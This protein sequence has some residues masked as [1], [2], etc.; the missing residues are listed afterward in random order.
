MIAPSRLRMEQLRAHQQEIDEAGQGLAREYADINRE[1][2]RRKDGGARAPQPAPYIKGSS[3]TMGPFLTLLEP[4]RTSPQRPPCCMVSRRPRRPRIDALIGR[5]ARCS[6]AQPRSRRKVRCLDDANP[7]PASAHLQCIPPRTHPYTK[8]RRP[9]GS[10]PSSL[11]INASA[12]AATYVASSTL[13]DVP[14]ATREKQRA[15]A[16]IPDVA[17]ATTATRTEARAPSCQALRPLAGTSS[18]LRSL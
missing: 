13:G 15:A 5:F 17:G 12:V 7:T 3:P 1:I 14:T 8:H 2:E 9:A 4:A 11:Y 18:T 10:P 6:S 16:I